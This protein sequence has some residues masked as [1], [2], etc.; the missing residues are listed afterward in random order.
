MR[1]IAALLLLSLALAMTGWAQATSSSDSSPTPKPHSRH[2]TTRSAHRPHRRA[3]S[4]A[5]NRGVTDPIAKCADGTYS[6]SNS[7]RGACAHH[8]GVKVWLR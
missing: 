3:R 1:K 7:H 6:S 4:A 2:Y 5:R 8:G